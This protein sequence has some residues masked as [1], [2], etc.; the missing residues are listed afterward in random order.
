MARTALATQQIARTGVVPS[1]TSAN[2]DGHSVANRGRT[3][4]HVKNGGGGS[5]NV[6]LVTPVTVGGRAVG[7]DVIAVAA[8]AEKM[9][10]PF[11]ESVYNNTDGTVSVDFSGVSSVTCAAFTL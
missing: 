9:I 8:G 4:V 5:I 6:T 11:Q 2:A 10:G 1:Y 3:F 7:D